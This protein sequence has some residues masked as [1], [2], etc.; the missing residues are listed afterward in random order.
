MLYNI[1]SFYCFLLIIKLLES[2]CQSLPPKKKLN[3][4]SSS[5][6]KG[7]VEDTA[8]APICFGSRSLIH[9]SSLGSSYCS[10]RLIISSLLRL[11]ARMTVHALLL[12][13]KCYGFIFVLRCQYPAQGSKILYTCNIL[14]QHTSTC[15]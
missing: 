3:M 8:N 6:F 13:L 12:N 9:A 5:F 14:G 7:I 4:H 11:A 10:T 15:V 2:A 1:I